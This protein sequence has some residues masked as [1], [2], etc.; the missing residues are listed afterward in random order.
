MGQWVLSPCLIFGTFS[1]PLIHIIAEGKRVYQDSR[2]GLL[3]KR[4]KKTQNY[5]RRCP[6]LGSPACAQ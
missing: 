1:F 4:F 2:Q 3:P 6:L 5:C